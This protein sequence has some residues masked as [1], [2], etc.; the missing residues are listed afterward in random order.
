MK[1]KNC[2]AEDLQKALVIINQKYEENIKFKRLDVV[3]KN[4]KTCQF[5]LTVIDSK[6][7][8]HRRGF[9]KIE[10]KENPFRYVAVAEGKRMAAACW[11]AH[12]DFFDALIGINKQAIIVSRSVDTVIDRNGG[13]WQDKNIGSMMFPLYYSEACDCGKGDD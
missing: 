2:T 9:P 12:G 4:G 7:P 13:N 11:H 1:A 3:A 5:T 6:K 10:G 8:G